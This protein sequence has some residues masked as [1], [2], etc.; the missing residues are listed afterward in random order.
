MTGWSPG[1][2]LAVKGGLVT[3]FEAGHA[4]PTRV[5][6]REEAESEQMNIHKWIVQKLEEFFKWVRSD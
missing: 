5:S 2:F 1:R 3:R 4:G 6:Y